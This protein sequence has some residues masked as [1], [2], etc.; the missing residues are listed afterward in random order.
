MYCTT[1][2]FAKTCRKRH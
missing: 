2:R 1:M